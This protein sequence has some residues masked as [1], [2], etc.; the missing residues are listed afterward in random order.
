[1]SVFGSV[2]LNLLSL[3]FKKKKKKK[4]VTRD[5]CQLRLRR[6]WPYIGFARQRPRGQTRRRSPEAMIYHVKGLTVPSL[7]FAWLGQITSQLCQAQT[8]AIVCQVK[9]SLRIQGFIINIWSFLNCSHSRRVE[10]NKVY[11]DLVSF[12]VYSQARV[13][14]LDP[15][16]WTNKHQ[17]PGSNTPELTLQQDIN[18]DDELVSITG[19]TIFQ[20]TLVFPPF[21]HK[22]FICPPPRPK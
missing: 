17:I 16:N 21:K 12:L 10:N 18:S 4:L 19:G 1:M 3:T 6:P 2:K 5:Q 8:Q 11:N 20:Q 9:L 15:G 14:G 7:V 13:E 22:I